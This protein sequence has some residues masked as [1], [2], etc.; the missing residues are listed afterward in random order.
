MALRKAFNV[1][2]VYAPEEMDKEIQLESSAPKVLEL[3]DGGKPATDE[4]KATISSLDPEFEIPETFTKQEAA[5]K[6][7]ELSGKK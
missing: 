4:Q 1:N 6:I 3:A 5:E 2:G 7:Q